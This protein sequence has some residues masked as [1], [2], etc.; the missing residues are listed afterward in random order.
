MK[1]QTE[2]F[3]YFG[4]SLAPI[5]QS[6]DGA[7]IISWDD[8]S[9]HGEISRLIFYQ[10]KVVEYSREIGLCLEKTLQ[11]MQSGRLQ[12]LGWDD[13]HRLINALL[14]FVFS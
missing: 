10:K 14:C 1:S 6:A 7:P 9:A 13:E 3:L 5:K 11:L 2:L 8:L 12:L 4:G